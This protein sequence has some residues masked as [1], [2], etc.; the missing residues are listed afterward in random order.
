M[1]D[2]VIIFL[3]Y[4]IHKGV[5]NF[6]LAVGVSVVAFGLLA[7]GLEKILL[8]SYEPV[9]TALMGS[10]DLVLIRSLSAVLSKIKKQKKEGQQNA[11]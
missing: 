5:K 11:E 3:A 7:I 9:W 8:K 1:I 4:V 6:F 2:P 10:A